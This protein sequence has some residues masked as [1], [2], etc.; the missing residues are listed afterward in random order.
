MVRNGQ[1]SR[2]P[3]TSPFLGVQVKFRPIDGKP[4]FHPNVYTDGGV[5][6]SIINP[7]ESTHGY[8]KGGTWKSTLTIPDVLKALQVFLDEPNVGS[9]AQD[10]AY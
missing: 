9:P 3:P 8:G 1:A 5:C 4:I 2:I 10:P 7:P 6:L